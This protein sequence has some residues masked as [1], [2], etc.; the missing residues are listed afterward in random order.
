VV[1]WN[2]GQENEDGMGPGDAC[3][4]GFGDVAPAG[5]PDGEVDVGDLV[6]L[7]RMAVGAEVP[8]LEER[9]RGDVAPALNYG[10]HDVHVVL[11]GV[12]AFAGIDLIMSFDDE[13]LLPSSSNSEG[14]FYRAGGLLNSAGEGRMR[15]LAALPENVDINPPVEVARIRY[16]QDEMATPD[17][18]LHG[19]VPGTCF[20]ADE[21]SGR[22]EDAV[23]S[24]RVEFVDQVSVPKADVQEGEIDVADV[25]LL[26]R[27]T[28]ELVEFPN[29]AFWP[30][31]WL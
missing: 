15:F 6:R 1:F 18:S 10:G 24:L 29:P 5:E 11:E 17:A 9:Q 7:L 16:I 14:P 22:L 12:T 2:P 4:W 28:V 31:P 3:G 26:L 21:V 13:T 30:N 23:C 25:I 8:T 27:A 19:V 20:V